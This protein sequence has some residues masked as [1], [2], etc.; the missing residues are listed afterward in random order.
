MR[1]VHADFPAPRALSQP[2]TVIPAKAGMQ[3]GSFSGR[4][5]MP[6]SAGMTDWKGVK[7]QKAAKALNQSERYTRSRRSW[8]SCAS[9]DRVAIGRAS[10]RFRLIGSPVSSQ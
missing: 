3:T 6:A 8:I 4:S 1:F 5:K 2:L 7:M 9:S 10:K